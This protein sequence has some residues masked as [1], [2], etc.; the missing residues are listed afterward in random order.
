MLIKCTIFLTNANTLQNFNANLS[1]FDLHASCPVFWSEN[2]HS[3][4]LR[5]IVNIY[6]YH[7]FLIFHIDT[8]YITF[9]LCL[10]MLMFTI[11]SFTT[12]NE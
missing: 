5:I 10:L 6:Y 12:G 11:S 2:L 8:F 1:L 7:H 4:K 3:F 9:F